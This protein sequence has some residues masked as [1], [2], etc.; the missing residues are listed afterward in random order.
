MTRKQSTKKRILV[1]VSPI[2]HAA[3]KR[4]AAKLGLSLS[5]MVRRALMLPDEKHG[6][7]YD[8]K[9]NGATR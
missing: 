1:E 5:N 2:Q 4:Q 3:L 8:L 6:K 9:Q 7:R